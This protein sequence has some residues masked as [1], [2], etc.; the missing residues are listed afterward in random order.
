M[1]SLGSNPRDEHRMEKENEKTDKELKL[2]EAFR[3]FDTEDDAGTKLNF[4]HL[5]PIRTNTACT[6]L[7]MS[8]S[9]RNQRNPADVSNRIL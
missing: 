2:I 9:C 4:L 8:F 1:R 3:A 5:L 7:E 6:V